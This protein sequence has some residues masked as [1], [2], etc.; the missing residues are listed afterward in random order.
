MVSTFQFLT[1][2]HF[3]ILD[4]TMINA[5]MSLEATTPSASALPAS[6]PIVSVIVP[7]C[8]ARAW[9]A[10]TIR[11]VISQ[12]GVNVEIL[13]IDDGSVDGSA[14]ISAALGAQMRVRIIQERHAGV[15][16]S[17][18][19]GTRLAR[20]EYLQYLDADD[21]LE[22]DTLADRV[23]ALEESGADVAYCDW[24]TWERNSDGSFALGTRCSRTLG[25]RPDIDLL[26][27]AWWPPGAILYRRSAVECIGEWD[28]TLP[29][30]QD[31]RFLLDAALSGS[32]FVHVM[33]P[34]LR[35]RV[36]DD[37]LSRHNPYA[38]LEDAYKNASELQ[39][40]WEHSATF[41]RARRQA[42][43]QIYQHL[44]RSALS[45]DS[46][47]RVDLAARIV[48]LSGP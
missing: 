26:A 21:L 2:K 37:S 17:R 47:I 19:L 34:G 30:V 31:A 7:C 38:V 32:S 25:Q 13:I 15:S 22:P 41:D 24:Y 46:A 36:R 44:L 35:Y 4:A 5:K 29:I 20:G 6:D 3:D 11:S 43:R 33:R 9:V 10:E 45:M 48:A 40:S 16:R 8:N 1:R 18:N 23:F 42:L 12:R 14:E 28:E 39:R 27:T